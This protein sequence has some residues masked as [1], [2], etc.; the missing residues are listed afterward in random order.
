M[1]FGDV[2][3]EGGQLR[4]ETLHVRGEVADSQL[5]FVAEYVLETCGWMDGWSMV[6]GWIDGWSVEDG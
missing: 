6:D 4:F 2:G 5:D 1:L 3:L